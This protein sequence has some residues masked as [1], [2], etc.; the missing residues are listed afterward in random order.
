MRRWR[1]L[2][3]EK[4]KLPSVDVN[5][6]M[7][8]LSQRIDW[9]LKQL[10]VPATWSI[11]KGEG[12]TAMVIDTGHPVHPDIGDNAIPG[13]NFI[14]NEPIEDE[15]G[16]QL[17]CTGIICAKDNETGMVGVAPEAKCISVKALAKN[18]GGSYLG[19]AQALDYAIEMKPDVVSMSLGGPS[20][21]SALQSRIKK[22]YDMN[23]PVVC[24]A[25]NT[26]EGGVNWPAAFDET[27]AVAAYDKYGK[28]AYFSSRGEKVEWAAPGV[29]IYST[30][31]NNGYASLSGTSMACPF[32]TGVICLMIAK[33]RKQEQATGMNDCK[34]V[35]EIREHLLKYTNDKGEV[36]RDNS[37]GY[38]VID[39]EKL[40]KDEELP[41]EEPKDE[42]PPVEEPKDE[43]PPVEE[44]KDEE[45]PVEEPKDEE[46]PVEEPKKKK[47]KKSLFIILG[48]VI[49]A[50]L[51]G[52]AVTANSDE[53]ITPPYIDESGNV[54]F[55][56][57]FELEQSK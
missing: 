40:I 41:V 18:G 4:T 13:K 56:K 51:I 31:L 53:D 57:K 33:H 8:S 49:I 10:N 46:P 7:S 25:G 20:P 43:E 48:V 32:I 38:G 54:D 52:F 2:Q 27:I 3:R 14:A 50:S 34:T 21:S 19:L 55:D 1:R 39:V 36:G 24:A 22:L 16:H 6:E 9:G 28:I 11:T 44:P 47:S 12:V 29:G 17:H 42:E 37:W 15:N 35:A 23:I 30:Y 45:P 26:G 5:E